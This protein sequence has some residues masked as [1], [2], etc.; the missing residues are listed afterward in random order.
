MQ[1]LIHIQEKLYN[2]LLS[3]ILNCQNAFE[4]NEKTVSKWKNRAYSV[5]KSSRPHTIKCS[6]TGLEKEIIRVVRTL[7][8]VELDDLVDSV[9]S[10]IPRANR[11]NVYRT[12]VAFGINRVPE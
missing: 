10:A 6:L 3:Q 2:S 5:D 7:T 4:I 11:S 1:K 9:L 12:L 8:W